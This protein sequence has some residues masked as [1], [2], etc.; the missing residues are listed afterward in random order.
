MNTNKSRSWR[1]A[2]TGTSLAL[3]VAL[4][5]AVGLYTPE[6]RACDS[7]ND[8]LLH[9]LT[10]ERSGSLMSRDLLAAIDNQRG[11]PLES[12]DAGGTGSAASAAAAKLDPMF[13]G[14][15]FIEVISRDQGLSI[16][17]T[18]FVPQDIEPD[19]T[20]NISLDEG[21]T[22]LGQGVMYDGFLANGG[23][24]GPTLRV[25]EGDVVRITITNT[26]TVPHATR[27]RCT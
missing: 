18:G 22:Y 11:L 19:H 2:V 27:Y 6:A 4:G 1:G 9:E 14:A 15:E 12:L 26:G 24:P 7:C 21:Q 20:F 25:T 8:T 3:L 10:H 5:S 23:V 16:P 17:A 13:E